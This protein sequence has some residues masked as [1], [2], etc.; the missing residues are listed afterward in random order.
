MQDGP[1]SDFGATPGDRGIHQKQKSLT[2][3]LSCC[4]FGRCFAQVK[5]STNTVDFFRKTTD[6]QWI[7]PI[8]RLLAFIYQMHPMIFVGKANCSKDRKIRWYFFKMKNR[9]KIPKKWLQNFQKMKAKFIVRNFL[10]IWKLIFPWGMFELWYFQFFFQ[11][12][13]SMVP[14]FLQER[15]RVLYISL[16]SAIFIIW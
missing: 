12:D 4:L 15:R 10:I 3:S 5:M 16:F 1:A 13:T 11:N 6:S 8:S 7:D 14:I 2:W 9:P